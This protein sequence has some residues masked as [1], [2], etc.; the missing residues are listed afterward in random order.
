ME[1]ILFR[2]ALI[3]A[4]L[5]AA[6][7]VSAP[8]QK[9]PPPK[10]AAAPAPLPEP[11]IP[12]AQARELGLTQCA[13]TIDKMARDILTAPYEAQSGWSGE[14]PAAHVFQSVAALSRAGNIP[15]D[16]LAALAALPA[17][18]GGCEGVTL[19]VFPLAGDCPSVQ[20]ALLNGGRELGPLLNARIMLDAGG[21]RLF[22]LPGFKSTCI[23][24]AV[25]SVFSGAK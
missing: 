7:A 18:G 15:P 4:L 3:L 24:V 1:R 10:P 17:P 2:A 16:G 19:Q 5:A 13:P 20:K 8:R 14:A 25:D 12:V 9:P 21:R 22:L 23:A 11:P 6:P